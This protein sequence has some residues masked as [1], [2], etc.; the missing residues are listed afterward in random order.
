MDLKASSII[1]L[2]VKLFYHFKNIGQL[3]SKDSVKY[4]ME[5]N[6]KIQG[7][8]TS[9]KKKMFKVKLLT[10]LFYLNKKTTKNS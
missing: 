7:Y 6:L 1:S 4:S 8:L 9:Y 3:L 5:L 2:K 10:L